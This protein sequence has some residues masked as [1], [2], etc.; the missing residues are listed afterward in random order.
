VPD[1]PPSPLLRRLTML[2]GKGGVGKSSLVAAMA[3]AAAEAG[4]NPL[5]VE[6]GHRASMEAIFDVGPIEYEPRE[7]G[8][9][10]SAM[11]LDFQNGL[12][13]Y[14][15]EQVRIKRAVRAIMNNRALQRFFAAA[16]SVAEVAVLNK[17]STLEGQRHLGGEPRWDPIVVDLD[18]TGHA[19]MLLNLPSVLDGLIGDGPMRALIDGFSELLSDPAR[20]V[21]HLVT[22]PRELPA[23]ETVEL[24]ERL[25]S[26]HDVPLGSLLVNQVP[27]RPLDPR[28]VARL[29]ELE[30]H[31]ADAGHVALTDAV[32]VGRRAVQRHTRARQQ[33]DRL[34]EEIA[35]PL[36]EL[37]QFDD[38]LD[39]DRLTELGRAVVGR[40]VAS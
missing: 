25:A 35:M 31:A 5:I 39:L 27:A 20:C 29:E 36:V 8:R 33:I 15:V 4:R 38:A 22:M 34:H 11:N 6:M 16:P 3:L 26:H 21:L 24:Y 18:A 30:H 23:Q 28:L 10:V 14:M 7:I 2:T 19:L 40:E 37:E 12:R 32:A 1:V 9:G 17:M 13:E